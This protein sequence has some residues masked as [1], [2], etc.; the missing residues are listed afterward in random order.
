M[1]KRT[2]APDIVLRADPR[3]VDTA[4]ALLV[5]V[6]V[7]ESPAR[8]EHRFERIM[9]RCGESLDF[10]EATFSAAQALRDL[11]TIDQ[12]EAA[13]IFSSLYSAWED[14]YEENDRVI[15]K[16]LQGYVNR[17]SEEPPPQTEATDKDP[18]LEKLLD[19]M[20][21]RKWEL[22]S[23]F[24]R[25]RGETSLSHMILEN[26]GQYQE[27]CVNG[28]FSLAIEDRFPPED[29]A[30]AEP[31]AKRVALIT[32][33]I[34]ALAATETG[35]E[36]LRAWQEFAEA[37]MGGDAAAGAAAVQR[38]RELGLV[39]ADEAVGL[40]DTV[41]GGVMSSAIE[42]D[43]ECARLRLAIDAVRERYGLDYEGRLSDGTV[44]P[45]WTFFD[46]QHERRANGVMA[47][48]LRRY[49]EHRSANLLVENPAEYHRLV[50]EVSVG[51][52][53]GPS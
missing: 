43:R 19:R 44:H 52:W 17:P 21:R 9:D 22:E 46:R 39:S 24:H 6:T 16:L 1:P 25:V 3:R 47:Y 26:P 50:D 35:R 45:E 2:H 32:E 4:K 15:Q 10:M 40:M 20:S 7:A 12:A 13:Y 18:R 36:T 42:A 49:G 28:Q 38:V 51:A 48:W 8:A 30:T 14:Q 31:D 41:L 37:E 11:G 34:I 27:L 33:R 53:G 23:S 5:M 29:D